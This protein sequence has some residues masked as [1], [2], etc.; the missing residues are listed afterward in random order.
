MKV[1]MMGNPLELRRV[2][3][4][5]RDAEQAGFSGM[6]MTEG[7]R[8]AFLSCA[9]AALATEH[10]EI[11]TGVAVAFP[12]SPTTTAANAWELADVSGGRF[13]LGLG[14]QVRTHIVRRY[15]TAFEHPGPRMEDYITAVRAVFASFRSGSLDHHGPFYELTFMTP[16][17]SAGN[18]AVDDPAV[19]VAAVNPWMLEMAGR[20]ADGVHIH[21]IG[22]IGYLRDIALPALA[23]GAAAAGRSMDDV[24]VIVPVFTVVG[25]TDEERAVWRE[26]ARA[27][28]AFYASTPSYSFILDGA[29]FEGLNARLRERQK[30]GDMAGMVAHI[31]DEML[32]KFTVTATWETLADRLIERYDGVADR[33][34]MYLAGPAWTRGETEWFQRL[35]IVARDVIERTS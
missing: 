6:V 17:W 16:Q 20:V 7:G 9:A 8:T 33:L 23:K 34:V 5:A 29:G 30:A 22:E 18:I 12:R 15:G 11:L 19:D 4:M 2:Q 21:P 24:D 1:D 25:E 28:I 14:T 10:L 26:H 35:G 13:R 27:Q 3:Q 32:E 31:S